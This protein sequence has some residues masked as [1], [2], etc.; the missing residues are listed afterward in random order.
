[1]VVKPKVE[2]RG[3]GLVRRS[4]DKRRTSLEKARERVKMR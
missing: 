3:D 2:G 4:R 1:M